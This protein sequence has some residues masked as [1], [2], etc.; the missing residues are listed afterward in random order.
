[1]GSIRSPGCLSALQ[2]SALVRAN[3][4]VAV[5]QLSACAKFRGAYMYLIMSVKK[6]EIGKRAA[7]RGVLATIR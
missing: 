7:E 5:L 3:S 6:A 4:E 2:T 1:M